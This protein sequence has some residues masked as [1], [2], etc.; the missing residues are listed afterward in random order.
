MMMH[1]PS[2]SHSLWHSKLLRTQAREW[3][4]EGRELGHIPMMP[5]IPKSS[6]T[7]KERDDLGLW[8]W[9]SRQKLW[10]RIMWEYHTEPR[11]WLGSSSSSNWIVPLQETQLHLKSLN[12]KILHKT[13]DSSTEIPP[14]S[15]MKWVAGGKMPI[16]NRMNRYWGPLPHRPNQS[17]QQ[18][19]QPHQ[20]Q[21]LQMHEEE[22]EEE[23]LNKPK[24]W[25]ELLCTQLD[26]THIRSNERKMET[27]RERERDLR[28]TSSLRDCERDW[29]RTIGGK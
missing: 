10:A 13:K 16:C 4:I 22:E 27:Q 19:N 20:T 15:A 28:E 17:K 12:T 18:K 7:Q 6:D 24:W 1:G 3:L 25:P 26:K 11:R 21:M 9:I 14:Q 23:K 29:D 5:R 8:V 2:S